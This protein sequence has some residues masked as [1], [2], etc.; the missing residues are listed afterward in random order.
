MKDRGSR[1]FKTKVIVKKRLVTG[2]VTSF[3]LG[4]EKRAQPHRMAK[5]KVKFTSPRSSLKF[6]K[7]KANR[8]ARHR[9]KQDVNAGKEPRPESPNSVKWDYW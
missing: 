9:V 7:Q 2:A 3:G 6:G 1:R 8:A 5:H 4:D